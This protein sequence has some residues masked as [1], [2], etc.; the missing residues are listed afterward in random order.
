MFLVLLSNVSDSFL[1][2]IQVCSEIHSVLKS[3]FPTSIVL[4]VSYNVLVSELRLLDVAQGSE[5]VRIV[6]FG[7]WTQVQTRDIPVPAASLCAGEQATA[8]HK[9]VHQI[10]DP[11]KILIHE[12]TVTGDDRDDPLQGD[13]RR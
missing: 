11:H 7:T 6:H 10:E 3:P 12:S 13:I 1:R 9:Q 5:V 4:D 2:T 8:E